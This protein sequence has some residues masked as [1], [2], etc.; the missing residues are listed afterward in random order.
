MGMLSPLESDV[1]TIFDPVT[2]M[3]VFQGYKAETGQ[4]RDKGE[5]SKPLDKKC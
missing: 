2:N 5:L 1:S 4:D 3:K